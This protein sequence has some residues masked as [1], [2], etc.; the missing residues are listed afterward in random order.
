M[1]V[2]FNPNGQ[3][4]V[5]DAE[6]EGPLG[7]AV[8]HLA[9]D[10]GATRSVINAGLLLAT[11]LDPATATQ[12]V[13]VTTGSGVESI[14]LLTVNRLSALGQ[15]RSGCTVLA[16]TLPPSANVDGV[17]GLD[18]LRGQELNINFRTGM[19]DLK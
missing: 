14:A 5:V 4:I 16:H 6:L 11:G 19:I 9:L 2:P 15:H 18:F 3:L 8:L 1:S 12:L 17:L 10:T 13:Q 7:T